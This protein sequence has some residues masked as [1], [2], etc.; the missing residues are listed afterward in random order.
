EPLRV[1]AA[2][3]LAAL[4]EDLAQLHRR[5]HQLPLDLGAQ[6]QEARRQRL[7]L[8][9]VEDRHHRRSLDT[10]QGGRGLARSSHGSSL[11]R[12]LADRWP[13]RKAPAGG[14]VV[15]FTKT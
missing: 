6:L 13:A 11:G 5:V 8:R 12:I 7:R 15:K 1:V 2:E 14:A 9:A 3:Q 4:A 10:R